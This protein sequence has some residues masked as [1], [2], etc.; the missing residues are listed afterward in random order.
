MTLFSSLSGVT[1]LV[2]FGLLV[3]AAV[4]DAKTKRIPPWIPISIFI[5]APF[6]PDFS[7]KSGIF[8]FLLLGGILLLSDIILPKA[9]GGGDIKL[10]AAVGFA[11]GFYPG[12]FGLL[13]ALILSM[14][15]CLFLQITKRKKF[16][17]F[18]P[19]LAIGF[20][21]STLLF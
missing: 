21:L 2:F 9:F 5:L 10:C 11:L 3:T 8:G 15:A 14:P 19:Y 13:I 7:L 12:G 17:A 1:L 18:G 20:I 16:M 4:V 6:M